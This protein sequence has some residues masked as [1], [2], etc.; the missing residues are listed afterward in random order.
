MGIITKSTLAIIFKI[1]KDEFIKAKSEIKNG[2]ISNSKSVTEEGLY[3]LDAIQNNS[4]VEGTLRNEIDT[5]KL[6]N[7]LIFH[8]NDIYDA[9][10]YWH[11]LYGFCGSN[12]QDFFFVVP[13]PKRLDISPEEV[14][15]YQLTFYGPKAAVSLSEFPEINEFHISRKQGL[16]YLV[17]KF[18]EPL[19]V[20]F[21]DGSKGCSFNGQIQ[22]KMTV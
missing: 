14:I 4:S 6:H 2:I 11:F 9:N 5:L 12:H 10:G 8:K 21:F 20:M 22:F 1:I 7:D 19:N 16:L 3:C 15:V 18:K 17:Y 13:L